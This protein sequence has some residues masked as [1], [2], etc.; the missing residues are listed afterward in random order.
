MHRRTPRA[1]AGLLVVLALTAGC[2]APVTL[3]KVGARPPLQDPSASSSPI[4]SDAAA[5]SY[6]VADPGP[7]TG[8]LYTAD[9]L[10][11]S[12]KPIPESVR[13]Q[14]LRVHGVD[15]A[16]PLSVANLS[17]NGRTLTIAAGD[18]GEFRRFTPATSAHADDV[19]SRVAGGEVAVDATLPRKLADKG[20]YLTLG[21]AKDA[22]AVHIGAYAPLVR[23]ISA[24]VDDKRAKQLQMVPRN[25]LLV[26]T[27]TFTPS[28]LTGRIGK[29]VGTQATLQT[30]ALEFNVDVP[31]TAVLTGGSVSSAVG[32]FH[33]T[34]HADGRVTPD[35]AWVHGYIRTESVP[36][37]GQV[38]CNK[39]M[40]VQLRAALQEVVQRGLADRIHPSEY[41]GCYYP[42]YIAYDPAQGLSL[43]TWGIAIDLNV[44]ENQRGTVGRMDRQVVAIFKKWGFAW[45][46]DWHYTDP[47]HFELD[48]LVRPH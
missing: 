22:P 28:A 6:A 32:S 17:S 36:I 18:P 33:Y 14:V 16:M 1:A 8:R 4:P 30:L 20:D 42:R 39:V 35:P 15:A 13:R 27:G 7:M 41:G 44:A 31:Q 34:P 12:R 25:A 46:G 47:M 48:A 21:T 10:V 45:G 5:P 24:F 23:Q 40:L 11:T 26:S 38:T 9:L 2:S 19:W 29:V 43:H 37:I 3:E